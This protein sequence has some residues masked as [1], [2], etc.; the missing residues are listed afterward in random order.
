MNGD[1]GQSHPLPSL[2]VC[3]TKMLYY[4]SC[5]GEVIYNLLSFT[6]CSRGRGLRKSLGVGGKSF[7]G[8]IPNLFYETLLPLNWS[9]ATYFKF[10]LR[11]LE[12]TP[13]STVSEHC[14]QC[15]QS[16]HLP[17]GGIFLEPVL[18]FLLFIFSFVGIWAQISFTITL[19]VLTYGV[20]K[21]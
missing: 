1:E 15:S 8:N 5:H 17:L 2:K 14:S 18:D 11:Q 20:L 4:C 19:D 9:T 3:E 7:P 10:L 12:Q 13:Q 6:H 21:L 16:K